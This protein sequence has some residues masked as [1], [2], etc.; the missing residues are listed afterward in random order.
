MQIICQWLAF[1][2]MPSAQRDV[3]EAF[4]EVHQISE[5]RKLQDPMVIKDIHHASFNRLF[6][7]RC[8]KWVNCLEYL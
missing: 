8:A 3:A 1:P 5:V 4:Y 6:E 7:P 2:N